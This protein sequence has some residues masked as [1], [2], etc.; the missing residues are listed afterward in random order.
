MAGSDRATLLEIYRSLG[1]PACAPLAAAMLGDANVALLS[2]AL[3]LRVGA[4]LAGTL[5]P[6]A[7][8]LTL[9]RS[10]SFANALMN[11]AMER[12]DLAASAPNLEGANRRVLQLAGDAIVQD[13]RLGARHREL[14]EGG[15]PLDERTCGDGGAAARREMRRGPAGVGIS[16][17]WDAYMFERN[18]LYETRP[19]HGLTPREMTGSDD[20]RIKTG[21][22]APR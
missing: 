22:W 21:L 8:E 18:L 12:G 7:E 14:L 2:R 15:V 6:A 5:A 3:A 20:W 9:R 10:A 19:F 17:P 16:S 1:G 11:V 4:R 13:A